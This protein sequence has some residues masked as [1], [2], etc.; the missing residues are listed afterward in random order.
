LNGVSDILHYSSEFFYG[1]LPYAAVVVAGLIIILVGLISDSPK[2]PESKVGEGKAA[3]YLTKVIHQLDKITTFFPLRWIKKDIKSSL[4]ITL[5]EENTIGLIS[6]II[7]LGIFLVSILLV[8]LLHKVGQLWYAK[9]LLAGMGLILPYYLATLFFD[10]YRY[11]IGR[12]VPKLID[13]FRSSF[14]RHNKIRLALKECSLYID[15]GLGRI[16]ARAA[17]STFI[18]QSLDTLKQ[19]FD[20]VWFNI[21]VVLLLNFKENGG[22]LI[23]QLYRLNRT[24]TRYNN[25]EK[26]K[27]NRLIWYEV[28]AVCASVFSIPAIFLIN[29]LILGSEQGLLIDAKTNMIIC[30]VIGFSILSLVIIRVLRRM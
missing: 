2:F 28:F 10:I 16:I 17:D 6:N 21:F 23:D 24:M 22:E 7:T 9:I 27:N 4:T 11:H 1:Y 3:L 5:F 26:K 18:E 29:N 30:Q 15:K 25:I 8:L 20:N 13:E 14:I 19:K 12:T